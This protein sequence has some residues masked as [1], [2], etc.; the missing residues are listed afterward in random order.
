MS[1]LYGLG[2]YLQS[3]NPWRQP[4]APA[5]VPAREHRLPGVI[6][7]KVFELSDATTI[8]KSACVDRAFRNTEAKDSKLWQ[9]QHAQ[10]VAAG[11]LQPA[12]QGVSL[13]AH[14]K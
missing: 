7:E 3:W 13:R 14:V 12:A 10:L 5:G 4:T 11:L 6:V 9:A 8:A 2:S 1:I